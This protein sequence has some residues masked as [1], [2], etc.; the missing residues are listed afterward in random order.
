ME[1]KSKVRAS[2]NFSTKPALQKEI[3]KKMLHSRVG[4]DPEKDCPQGF[5]LF[6]FHKTECTAIDKY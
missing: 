2:G 1:K 5:K 6:M 4:V 3:G